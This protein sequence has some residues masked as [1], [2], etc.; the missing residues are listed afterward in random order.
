MKT[1]SELIIDSL[2][3]ELSRGG[4]SY[5]TPD[6][7]NG[8]EFK[9]IKAE[10]SGITIETGGG[11]PIAISRMSFVAALRFLLE[12]GHAGEHKACLIGANLGDPG[13]L[14]RAARLH[15][16]NTMVIPYILPILAATEIVGINGSRPNRTWVNL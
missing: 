15:S 11:S 1:L 10:P 6:G 4:I 7:H 5:K 13:P 2:W 12:H 14:D 9:V 3:A 16:E 8:A